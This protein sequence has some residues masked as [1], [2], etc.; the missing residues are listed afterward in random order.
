MYHILQIT[1]PLMEK[2][3]QLLR[4]RILPILEAVYATAA[5]TV[6]ELARAQWVKVL[7]TQAYQPEV[8]PQNPQRKERIYLI[9]KV[10]LNATQIVHACTCIH[11]TDF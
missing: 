4:L 5:T 6:Q 8:S 2:K 7:P 11:T 9:F 10:I 3:L 1:A